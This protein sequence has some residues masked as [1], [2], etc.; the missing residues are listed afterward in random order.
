MLG[1]AAA[2]GCDATDASCLCNNVRFGYGIRDC[3][4]AVCQNGN[5]ETV[6][7]FGVSYCAS[8]EIPSASLI[9]FRETN[10]L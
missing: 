2:L 10:D 3:A 6:I 7:Q 9:Y 4:D 1:Q 8:G 5:A